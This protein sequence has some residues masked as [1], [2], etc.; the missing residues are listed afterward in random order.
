MIRPARRR[1]RWIIP[2]LFVLLAITAVL[3]MARPAPSAR[4]HSLP[5]AIAEAAGLSK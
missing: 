3:A 2:G 5:G 4:V 1:H